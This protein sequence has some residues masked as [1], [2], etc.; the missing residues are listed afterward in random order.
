M[1]FR[2]IFL[3]NLEDLFMKISEVADINKVNLLAK[4]NVDI[5]KYLDTSNLTEGIIDEVQILTKGKDKIPSRAKRKVKKDDILIST[6]RP[7]LKHYGL[8]KENDENLIVST[9]FAVLTPNTKIVDPRYLYYYLTSEN[10]TNYLHMVACTSTT[11]YP[12]IKPSVIGDI[13]IDLPT[14]E[15][16]KKIGDLLSAIDDKIFLNNELNKELDELSQLIFEKW[17]NENEAKSVELRELCSLITDGSHSSPTTVE[18]GFPMAS[19]KDM[20]HFSIDIKKC[21][22]ISK[23]DYDSLVKGNCKP[24]IND[25]LVAKDGSYLKHIIHVKEEENIVLLSSI[26]ILRPNLNKIHPIILKRYLLIPSMKKAL[27]DGYVT[28][29]ALKR[30]ILKS[31]RR[32]PIAVPSIKKQSEIIDILN[33]LEDRIYLNVKENEDLNTLRDTLISQIFSGKIKIK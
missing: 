1:N 19:V 17:L 22:N 23:D 16:Q 27:E 10:I 9:G 12:S 15:E 8:I 7:N 32:F 26:A 5:I 14:I 18:T 3:N 4:E 31:F 2:K 20:T 30:I 24:K 21:R 6:V 11:S 28:G 29:T 33:K 25:I 13:N